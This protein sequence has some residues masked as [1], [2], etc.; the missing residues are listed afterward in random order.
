MSERPVDEA[1][2][3]E[4]YDSSRYPK[5]SVTV[6]LVVFTVVDTDLKLLLIRRGNPPHQG[7]LA[8]PGGFLDVSPPPL[9][10]PPA[11][12]PPREII[13]TLGVLALGDAAPPS[14]VRGGGGGISSPAPGGSYRGSDKR[15]ESFTRGGGSS[16]STSEPLPRENPSLSTSSGPRLRSSTSMSVIASALRGRSRWTLCGPRTT[17]DWCVF[18]CWC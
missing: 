9:P 13:G 2:F 5:P 11:P 6:D 15:T 1:A 17:F 14:A 16:T 7:A 8:L 12:T 10:E 18:D 4:S 3:L